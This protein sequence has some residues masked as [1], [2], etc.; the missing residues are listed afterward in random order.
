MIPKLLPF[1]DVDVLGNAAL[2][3]EDPLAAGLA[4]WALA[5]PS[6]FGS[7]SWPSLAGKNL[8][9]TLTNMTSQLT[10]RWRR[11]ASG[12]PG[13]YGAMAFN[14]GSTT[15]ATQVKWLDD[16]QLKTPSAA[17]TICCWLYA[18]SLAASYTH[19]FFKDYDGSHSAYGL[20]SSSAK[21][22]YGEMTD[23]TN[24]LSITGTTTLA[25]FTWY[26]MAMTY[27][28]ANQKIWLNGNAEAT[29]SRGSI[30]LGQAAQPLY[31]GA[32]IFNT[33]WTG[34]IDD[35]R[36]Y[37][38]YQDPA[39]IYRDS[40]QGCPRLLRKSSPWQTGKALSA[41]NWWN[42]SQPMM[43]ALGSANPNV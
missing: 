14:G 8:N 1:G 11:G 36:V 31:I 23:G 3:R 22:P 12:R 43:G 27:D 9:G 20:W 29:T 16:A 25:Q 41:I 30:T 28:G 38:T 33:G 15:S 19:I 5:V 39:A 10:T 26:H 4:F 24:V 13:G 35:V 21:V 42:Y 40:L 6:L 34:L 7:S 18:T 32:G 2:N 17:M 37:S